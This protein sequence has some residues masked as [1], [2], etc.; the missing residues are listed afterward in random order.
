MALPEHVSKA[1]ALERLKAAVAATEAE[2]ATR[3]ANLS[4]DEIEAA[5]DRRDN[6]ISFGR[7]LAKVRQAYEKE[8]NI[9]TRP[10]LQRSARAQSNGAAR[11]LML[12]VDQ[13]I[14]RSSKDQDA[15]AGEVKKKSGL[16]LVS[17]QDAAQ[18]CRR[19]QQK[20]NAK[21]PDVPE[22]RLRRQLRP[23]R[24]L[25]RQ[26]V[27]VKPETK[28]SDLPTFDEFSK[29]MGASTLMEL[30]EASAAYMTLVLGEKEYSEKQISKNL[31]DH[32][33]RIVKKSERLGTLDNLGQRGYMKIS[34]DGRYAL[35]VERKAAYQK[36]YLA[37]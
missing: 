8:K 26:T 12:D 36:K 2:R 34:E 16:T 11:P 3:M 13:R 9:F 32:M 22:K 25:K 31:P 37:S 30:L 10:T 28:A 20:E 14:D 21:P 17:D 15:T 27:E 29:V 19:N 35:S 6:T 1:N 33:K 23:K 24:T 18:K 5:E 4:V 7:E